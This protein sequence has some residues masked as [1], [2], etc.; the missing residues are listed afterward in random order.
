MDPPKY[1]GYDTSWIGPWELSTVWTYGVVGDDVEEVEEEMYIRRYL[2]LDGHEE[3]CA[4]E[5]FVMV[6]R[7]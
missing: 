3:C 5:H 2:I 6:P 1:D 4:H 7:P